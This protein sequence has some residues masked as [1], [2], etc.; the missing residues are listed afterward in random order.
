MF[1]LT[2]GE[3]RG[4]VVVLALFAIGTVWDL[5]HREPRMAPPMPGV[6]EVAAAAQLSSLPEPPAAIPDA[7]S[8]P[9]G[10]LPRRGKSP[11]SQPL[12]L[13][14]ASAQDLAR[15]PGI[16]PVLAQRIVDRRTTLGGFRSVED[17]LAVPGIGPRLYERIR[18]WLHV[19][20]AVQSARR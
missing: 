15:L 17:L 3:R 13:A 8:K 2:P 1:D 14:T 4:A 20:P 9:A 6:S 7:A 16:G 10:S 5:V 18:P 11:P 12:P 19:G